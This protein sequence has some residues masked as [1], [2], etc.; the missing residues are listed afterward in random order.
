MDGLWQC[1][2]SGKAL[3]FKLGSLSQYKI[4][5]CYDLAVA[6][7]NKPLVPKVKETDW[8]S[9]AAILPG[10][11]NLLS[12][13]NRENQWCFG[14]C[15]FILPS[16][17]HGVSEPTC[18]ELVYCYSLWERPDANSRGDTGVIKGPMP[19]KW[20]SGEMFLEP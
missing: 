11:P 2:T 10:T 20:Q 3:H 13:R 15:V 18:P 12:V 19:S 17:R 8:N 16:D 1:I 7:N 4:N 9:R 6:V 14:L 5:R